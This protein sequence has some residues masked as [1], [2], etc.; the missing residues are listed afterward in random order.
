MAQGVL[1]IAEQQDGVFRKVSFEAVSEGR[2]IAD[3]LNTDLTAVVLGS[4]IEGIAAELK[5]Y[6]ADTI[7]YA[8]DPA[9]SVYT[10]EGYTNVLADIIKSAEPE[11]IIIGASI[12]GK[13]LSARLAARIDA[14]LVMDCTAIRLDNGNL[15]F[16]RPVYGGKL[17]SDLEISGSPKIAAIRP[18]VMTISEAEKSSK[19]EKAD[20]QPGEIKTKVIETRKEAEDKVNLAEADVVVSGGRG[21]GGDFAAME[22]LANLLRGAVG[23]SRPVV[24]EGWR[25]HSDQV[26]QTGKT[27]SPN[28]YIAC[29]ISGAIQHIAGMSG[30][31]VIVAINKDSE[32]PIFSKADYGVVADYSDLVPA[33]IEEIKKLSE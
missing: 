29:A 2:R 19:I 31:K 20:V 11:L 9:I 21:T 24:D 10:T 15:I 22:E 26:G 5:K 7:L 23:A 18:N 30:A 33:I 12:Q 4:G 16:S 3:G 32:A 8:D 27:V 14:G 28:L 25:L 6:G 17:I 1:I 13:D